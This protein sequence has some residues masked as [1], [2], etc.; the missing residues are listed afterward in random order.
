[1]RKKKELKLNILPEKK[2]DKALLVALLSGIVSINAPAFAQD[3]TQADWL[4]KPASTPMLDYL[5]AN[6]KSSVSSGYTLKEVPVQEGDIP[7]R[8]TIAMHEIAKATKYYHPTT[9]QVVSSADLDSSTE[10]Y[11]YEIPK[12]SESKY[13]TVGIK[14]PEYGVKDGS[15]A[16]RYFNWNFNNAGEYNLVEAP[17]PSGTDG[18][19]YYENTNV[20]KTA[21]PLITNGVKEAITNTNS[22][23]NSVSGAFIGN[24]AYLNGGVKNIAQAGNTAK[25]GEITGHFIGNSAYVGTSVLE[26][27]AIVNSGNA[28]IDNIIADF[29]GNYLFS[30][31]APVKGGAIFNSKDSKITSITGDFIGNSVGAQDNPAHGAAIYNAGTIDN[32]VGGFYNNAV[33]VNKIDNNGGAIYNTGLITSIVGEFS[34]NTGYFGGAV[35]NSGTIKSLKADFLKQNTYYGSV[36]NAGVIDSIEGNFI[37]N[38]GYMSA[39]VHNI[40]GGEIKSIAGYFVGNTSFHS[41]AGM[42]IENCK[43]AKIGTIDAVFADNN[44]G[45]AIENQGGFI[46]SIIS[47]FISNSGGGINNYGSITSIESLFMDN[48]Y[49]GVYNKKLGVINSL[50]SDFIGNKS[51][52]IYNEYGIVE[53]IIG[54]FL[55][56]KGKAVSNTY[57]T[58][59]LIDGRFVGN[60]TNYS[61]K[62]PML[63]PGA[64][65][66]NHEGFIDLIMGD[67]IENT[68]TGVNNYGGLGGAIYNSAAP[69][70]SKGVIEEIRADFISNGAFAN[71]EEGLPKDAFGG[72]IYNE[73]TINAIVNSNFIGN[74]VKSN[75]GKALGGAIYSKND[76]N[77]IAD[78]GVSEFSGN[79]V[80]AKG[81]RDYQAIY[82]GFNARPKDEKGYDVPATLNLVAK[83]NGTLLFNDKISGSSNVIT[84]AYRSVFD[85]QIREYVKIYTDENRQD[86]TDTSSY[87]YADYK[88]KFDGDST[89][90]IILNNNIEAESVSDYTQAPRANLDLYTVT[91]KLGNRDNVLD[92]N[93]LT[94]HSGTLDMINGEVGVADLNSLNI[95]G[96]TALNVDVDLVS[97]T[98]DTLKAD[99]YSATGGKLNVTGMN[100]LNDAPEGQDVTE[101]PFADIGLK[102]YVQNATGGV[103]PQDKYQIKTPIYQYNVAYENRPEAGYFLFAKGDKVFV[104]DAGGNGGV[105]IKPSGNPSDAFNPAVLASPVAAQVGA[106]ST[107]GMTFNYA[108]QNSDNFMANPY[109]K[110]VATRNAN[111]YA[112]AASG[113]Y[114]PLYTKPDTSSIWVKPYSTFESV[115]LKNGPKVSNVAY[116]TLIGFDSEMEH[117][118]RGWDRVWTGYVGYNGSNQSFSGVDTTQSGGL[119]GATMTMY[120]GNFF[121]A[122]TLTT[123][124]SVGFTTNMYG[125]E[126]FSMLMAGVGNKSGYNY[127]FKDGK[128]IVQPS[129]LV[130]Y[131]FVNTF[132]YR[133]AAGVKIEAD[134]LHSV[135]LVPGLKVIGNLKN[136]WQPYASVNMVWNLM[137]KTDFTANGVRLPEM[138]IKPYVQYGVGVQKS[139][140]DRSMAFGQVMIRNGGRNGV[141]LSA[142]FRWAIG[143]EG[144]PIEKVSN[145]QNVAYTLQ[146]GGRKVL[147]QMNT[148]RRSL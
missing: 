98:M 14:Q 10:Y 38:Y 18:I 68:T 110:R 45:F 109:L 116:G 77:I 4:Q 124:A 42:V 12:I 34:G 80:D 50:K 6:S 27:G 40:T 69:T 95:A 125:N 64:A 9:G 136:G 142:G 20:D 135:Q 57:G 46:D 119:V 30:A 103:L 19:K 79:Y 126:H 108:F 67:F 5:Y 131:S 81:Q 88:V 70:S 115:S 44:I 120:K 17:Y 55:S 90:K 75:Y 74:Y 39:G 47:D 53:S 106:M 129:M 127:E 86:L 87:T 3:I 71:D 111:K 61:N 65:I 83:N 15:T 49:I 76:L 33:T 107:M 21:L 141:A 138:S 58:I 11:S 29:V 97:K 85:P 36:A 113:V 144:K 100:L 133:N 37:D 140:K 94:M 112:L 72:A 123:G 92:G 16:T 43:D 104:P 137:G 96:D 1:M 31:Q 84:N 63:G 51:V 99:Y 78:N 24:N 25:I 91:L 128:I 8:S 134:P 73:G 105:D 82:I 146:S 32:I 22:T 59:G 93:N 60:S 56:N 66:H 13:Y 132:D 101:I 52:S 130:N 139:I 121:N 118:K 48:G 23:L 7:P 117:L 148:P 54:D 26:G 35:F 62:T 145:P 28:T 41:S 2:S 143:K 114:S 122:T 89:G 102:D 147:K